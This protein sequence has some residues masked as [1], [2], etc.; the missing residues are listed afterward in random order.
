[1]ANKLCLQMMKDVLTFWRLQEYV[2]QLDI[3]L[4]VPFVYVR[5]RE[6]DI[7]KE[8]NQPNMEQF[9][10]LVCE[11]YMSFMTQ[12]PPT[13][14]DE[15]LNVSISVCPCTCVCVRVCVHV[16]MQWHD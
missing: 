15:R 7:I 12:R 14:M 5:L 4:C 6:T 10:G 16:Y 13:M 1:M 8:R 9:T 3:L 2:S 11:E